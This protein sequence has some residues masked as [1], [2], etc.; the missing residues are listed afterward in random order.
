MRNCFR[1]ENVVIAE[2]PV[3][4]GALPASLTRQ[5]RAVDAHAFAFIVNDA[6]VAMVTAT[7]WNRCPS[8]LAAERRLAN[9]RLFF[10][11]SRHAAKSCIM[12]AVSYCHG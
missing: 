2:C 11:A 3:I 7:S 4:H 6:D 5:A 10:L 1:P 12:R 9:P 8:R